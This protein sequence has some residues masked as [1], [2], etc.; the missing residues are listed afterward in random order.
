[1]ARDQLPDHINDLEKQSYNEDADGNVGVRVLGGTRN[2]AG[3]EL[4]TTLEQEVRDLLSALEEMNTSLRIAVN[5]LRL[6][7]NV[8]TDEGDIY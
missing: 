6:I 4:S 8:N 1:M 5:H 3:V 2:A 7:T